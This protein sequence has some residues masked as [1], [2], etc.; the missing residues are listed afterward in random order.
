MSRQCYL[1]GVSCFVDASCMWWTEIYIREKV[2]IWARY[3]QPLTRSI[4]FGNIML[5]CFFYDGG[6][7]DIVVRYFLF[8]SLIG[9]SSNFSHYRKGVYPVGIKLF[10]NPPECTKNVCGIPILFKSAQN[11]Y[12]YAHSYSVDKYFIVSR[13]W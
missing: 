11:S 1:R 8:P 5:Y 6:S 3:V 4:Y 9:L 13:E 10:N 12:L 2:H 7:D